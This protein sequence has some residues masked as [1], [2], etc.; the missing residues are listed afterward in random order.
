MATF[1]TIATIITTTLLMVSIVGIFWGV[2][3]IIRDELRQGSSK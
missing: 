2:F 3:S 1:L